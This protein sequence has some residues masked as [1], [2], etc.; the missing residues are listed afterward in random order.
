MKFR[1]VLVLLFIWTRAHALETSSSENIEKRAQDLKAYIEKEKVLFESRE[2]QKKSLLTSLDET[3]KKQN[4]VRQKLI[5]L[6]EHQQEL[7]MSLQN[8]ALE[9]QNQKRIQQAQRERLFL[10]LKVVY[11][12]Q[13]QGMLPFIFSGANLS[14]L[15]GRFRVLVYT[16]RAHTRLSRQF[17]ERLSQLS[18]SE[19][20]LKATQIKLNQLSSNL[21]DQKN[22]LEQLLVNKKRLVQEINQRQSIYRKAANE[23]KQVSQQISKLFK[24]LSTSPKKNIQK[25]AAPHGNLSLPVE[26][27]IVQGFGKSIHEKFKTVTYHKGI[28]IESE[29]NSPV[30]S[31][32][33]GAVEY[34]GWLRG[35]GNV[36][37]LHH[38][39]GLYTLNAHLFKFNK[40][41]GESVEQGEVIGFVG[42]TGNSEKP[43]LYFEVRSN[44]QAVDPL[45]YITTE[46][47][48]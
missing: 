27:E 1:W 48:S 33:P 20:K 13:K 26:G 34:A 25:A 23:Y 29:F 41:V 7:E 37:I 3:N 30:I 14:Q 43:S 12:I 42:D 32:L 4:S 31:I 18:D 5:E 47:V 21:R 6:S 38:G 36:M 9:Y 24:D 40:S 39:E 8:L 10:I 15:A 19:F 2:F 46:K 45:L 44:G 28:L 11:Q 17:E 16:L 35:L 22:L